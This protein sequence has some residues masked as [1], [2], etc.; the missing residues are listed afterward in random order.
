VERM[1]GRMGVEST[2]GTGSTFWFTLPLPAERPIAPPVQPVVAI[3]LDDR[4]AAREAICDRLEAWKTPAL[5]AGDAD[6]AKRHLQRLVDR[7]ESPIVLIAAARSVPDPAVLGRFRAM[8]RHA[9][10]VILVESDPRAEPSP[11]VDRVLTEPVT[12]SRLADAILDVVDPDAAARRR[13]TL[14]ST[15]PA[16]RLAGSTR[17]L[18]VEDNPVNRR[19]ASLML[20]K[21]GLRC[22]LANNGKEALRRWG[23]RPY[24]LIL[25]DCQMPEMDGYEAT[26][27][28]RRLEQGGH[29]PIIAMTAEAM[30][31]DRERCIAAG[32]DDYIPKPV[33]VEALFEMLDRYLPPPEMDDDVVLDP[34]ASIED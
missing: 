27:H 7:R 2:P 23:E 30:K 16:G 29:T 34:G 8:G 22:D 17:V 14:D 11:L 33:R 31:G 25:M 26:R 1:G 20:R 5:Q 3:V 4:E 18:L 24:A 19:V 15:A 9:L 12:D 13:A 10:H 32:M 21:R 28:I 6:T